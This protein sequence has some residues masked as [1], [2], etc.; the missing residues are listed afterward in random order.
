[1][2]EVSR[3]VRLDS[4]AGNPA[5][6][7][8]DL[9][10][11]SGSDYFLDQAAD[12]LLPTDVDLLLKQA[13]PGPGRERS[14]CFIAAAELA[15]TDAEKILIPAFAHFTKPYLSDDRMRLAVALARLGAEPGIKAAIDGFF[16]EAPQ[17]G[18][19]G[20]GREAFLDRL[21][22]ADP[23]RF[24]KVAAMIARDPRLPTLGPASTRI[25]I[26]AA[27]G[28]LGRKLAYEED[29]RKS[30]G[31]DE[32]QRD[33]QFEPLERWQRLLHDSVQQSDR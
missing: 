8:P 4:I 26:L 14:R 24:R 20:F 5:I 25:L 16:H 30:D 6:D 11:G 32:A 12:L 1:M 17:P 22:A 18:A 19:F 7:D 27:Q 3:A 31:I 9:R 21:H 13:A 29:L 23:V 15:P 33:T 10:R 2:R 28:Y